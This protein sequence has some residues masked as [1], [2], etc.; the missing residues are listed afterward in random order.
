VTL[1]LSAPLAAHGQGSA[2][3]DECFGFSFGTFTPALDFTAAGHPGKAAEMRGSPTQA[4]GAIPAA[5][6]SAIRVEDDPRDSL[7]ILYPSWW[8][9]GVSV[10]WSKAGWVGDTLTGVAQAFVADGAAKVPTSRVRGWRVA[11]GRRQ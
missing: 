7:L 3:P 11:C 8:P 6:E 10:H 2:A 5:R 4:P 1:L 9:A